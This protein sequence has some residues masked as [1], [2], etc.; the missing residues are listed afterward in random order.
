M[1]LSIDPTNPD[2][3]DES[4]VRRA[5]SDAFSV[6]G[7]C[8]RCVERCVS[9]PTLFEMLDSS[10]DATPGDM[11]PAEQDLV[12]DGCVQCNLCTS[13]CPYGPGKHEMEL[14]VARL[15]LRTTAM[16]RDNR[17]TTAA[18]RRAARSMG[19]TTVVG[20][21]AVRVPTIANRVVGAAPGS[22]VRWLLAR[23]V[24]VSSRRRLPVFARERFSTWFEQ[25]PRIRIRRSQ[26]SVTIVPTCIVEFQ[27]TSIGKDLVKVYERN[28]VE[29]AV[30]GVRCCGAPLLHAG[31]VEGFAA[32]AT[33]N[34]KALAAEIRSGTD[35]VVPQPGCLSMIRS[36]YASFVHDD[37]RADAQFVAEHSN[38][39]AEYLMAV[40]R[41]DDA[42]LDTDFQGDVPGKIAFHS[43]CHL[44]ALG[45][46]FVGRDL[47]RLTGARVEVVQQCSGIDGIWGLRAA[48][49]DVAMKM[50]AKFVAR[51]GRSNADLVAGDCSLSNAV[52]EAHTGTAPLH[53]IEVMARAYGIPIER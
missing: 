49:D 24:G 1:T 4:A 15:M 35:V 14:D 23:L 42:V 2:H 53:P 47:M 32:V 5:L 41:S 3:V 45:I 25:R 7:E 17:H 12:V 18:T 9:F 50:G 37:L 31:D 26:R 33:K 30:S 6:C 28:G 40:H 52:V 19:R 13:T 21:L 8:R 44:R 34:V 16:R 22:V 39:P 48:N 11:T 20:R 51:V 46:G 38:D 29:C 36:E 10:P 43:A 27:Q